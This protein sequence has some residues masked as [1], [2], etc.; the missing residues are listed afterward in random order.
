MILKIFRHNFPSFPKWF[1]KTSELPL[2]T[3]QFFPKYLSKISGI[4]FEILLE[5]FQNITQNF[6]KKYSISFK[7]LFQ[8]YKNREYRI[9]YV[10]LRRACYVAYNTCRCD[11]VI[12]DI[13]LRWSTR[14][15]LNMS[16]LSRKN[17]LCVEFCVIILLHEWVDRGQM[18]Q[19]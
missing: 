10:A 14:S 1:S 12:C 5:I 3:L 16:S 6:L 18:H 7:I 8:K 11:I 2:K 17:L 13:M 4:I 9:R 19:L 15:C